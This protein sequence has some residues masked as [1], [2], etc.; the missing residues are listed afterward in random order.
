[1]FAVRELTDAKTNSRKEGEAARGDV[2]V[3][4]FFARG[5]A[6]VTLIEALG[7]VSESRWT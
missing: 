4:M 1:V 5:A 2:S 7:E 6:A 3:D